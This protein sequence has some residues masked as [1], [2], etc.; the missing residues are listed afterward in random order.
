MSSVYDHL[1]GVRRTNGNSEFG[2]GSG[3][4]G[5]EYPFLNEL[6]SRLLWKG[7]P[8][9]PGSLTIF[10][11]DGLAVVCVQDRHFRRKAFIGAESVSEALE[12]AETGLRENGLSWRYE[13]A[14]P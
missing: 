14:R 12:A 8:V 1:E 6:L 5:D 10:A 4:F 3:G 11:Q 9:R 2:F 7:K 13:K